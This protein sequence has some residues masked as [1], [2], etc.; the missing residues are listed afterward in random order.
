MNSTDPGTLFKGTSW[1]QIT[2]TFLYCANSS[3]VTG[4]SKN[5]SVDQLPNHY[6]SILNY[7]DNADYN[8]GGNVTNSGT[9]DIWVNSIPNDVDYYNNHRSTRTTYT[10]ETGGNAEFMP[11]Y[12][13]VYA[14]YRVG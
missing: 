7:Y 12:I 4:G 13:T 3:G 9:S 6:H 8:Q 1:K 10:E 2:D 11:P 5:I 14:W